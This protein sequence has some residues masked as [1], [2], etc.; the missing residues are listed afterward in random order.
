MGFKRKKNAPLGTFYKPHH[1]VRVSKSDNLC[2]LSLPK[3][4]WKVSM[5]MKI[6]LQKHKRIKIF[7]MPNTFN[8]E[9][10]RYIVVT[11]SYNTYANIHHFQLFGLFLSVCK[12][13]LTHNTA[14]GRFRLRELGRP[15][16]VCAPFILKP[17]SNHTCRQASHFN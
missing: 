16:F 15:L 1:A 12:Q 13:R 4:F 14:S 6:Q 2:Q 7:P 9:R 17:G 10:D 5:E 11:S 8:A 3:I